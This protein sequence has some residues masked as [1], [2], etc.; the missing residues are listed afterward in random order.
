MKSIKVK[1]GYF[2][3]AGVM[4]ML[5]LENCA[6]CKRQL[7]YPVGRTSVCPYC[8]VKLAGVK[9]CSASAKERIIYHLEPEK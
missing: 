9:L 4:T 5:V 3:G 2:Q 1:A 8:K 7:H 6:K